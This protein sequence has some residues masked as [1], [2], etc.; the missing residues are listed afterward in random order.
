MS[1]HPRL[2]QK[3]N[4]IKTVVLCTLTVLFTTNLTLAQTG[5]RVP[6]KY[7]TLSIDTS[8]CFQLTNRY[9]LPVGENVVLSNNQLRLCL[10]VD[11]VNVGTMPIRVVL[12]IDF[13]G[14]MCSNTGNDPTN[15]RLLAAHSFI[16]SLARRNPNSEAG[17]VTF[18]AD[19][20]GVTDVVRPLRL[21]TQANIDSLH[22]V[23]Y[24]ARCPNTTD[25]FYPRG[26]PKTTKRLDTYQG[27]AIDSALQVVDINY[28]AADSIARH[29]LLLTDDGWR[30]TTDH[31]PTDVINKY[32]A[33][34][35]GR[36]IPVIHSVFLSRTSA[37]NDS[38]LQAIANL[39]HGM[40]IPNA[41][42]TTI[43]A[44]FMEILRSISTIRRQSLTQVSISNITT[45]QTHDATLRLVAGSQS[46]YIVSAPP[47]T[48][49]PGNNTY[50][51]SKKYTT[52]TGLAV[53]TSDTLFIQRAAGDPAMPA[54]SPFSK[55]CIVDTFTITVQCTPTRVVT[56]APITM[57]AQVD[58]AKAALFVAGSVTA[59]AL[60]T[61]DPKT[62]G[63]V[64][65]FHLDGYLTDAT[66]TYVA[67]G[68]P[69][70]SAGNAAFKSALSSGSFSFNGASLVSDCALDLWVNRT[71]A[72]AAGTL[73]NSALFSL[74]MLA[75]GRVRFTD[76]A[77]TITSAAPFSIGIWNHVALA[78]SGT[79]LVLFVNG[80]AV[81]PSA[82]SGVDLGGSI[83][84][85]APAGCVVDEVRISS[86]SRITSVGTVRTFQIP[87][88][89]VAWN[90][91]GV[92]SSGNTAL[93]PSALW[94]TPTLGKATLTFS[95]PLSCGIILSLE[96]NDGENDW[97]I[98]SNPVTISPSAIPGAPITI[99]LFD[100]NGNGYL[101]QM[102]LY[103]PDTVVLINPLPTAASLMGS[104]TLVT[105]HN[106]SATLHAASLESITAHSLRIRL[107][108][109]SG[110]IL[111]TGW[112]SAS[113]QFQSIIMTSNDEPFAAD[114]VLDSA[115]PVI[116]AAKFYP[117]AAIG[118]VDTLE[119]TL[120]EPISYSAPTIPSQLFNY[121]RQVAL[122]PAAFTGLQATDFLP[123]GSERLTLRIILQNGF[124]V[125]P[126]DS[127]QLTP[128][129]RDNAANAAPVN[130]R[131]APIQWAVPGNIK[132]TAGPNPFRIGTLI[133][134]QIRQFYANIIAPT[135]PA[136][137]PI[138][139]TIIGI[140][141]DK[142]LKIEADGSVGS[143][144]ILDALGNTV[145]KGL[146]VRQAQTYRDYGV[147]WDGKNQNGR[148][149]GNGTYLLIFKVTDIDNQSFSNR[150][151]I[152]VRR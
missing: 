45:G 78:R 96:H 42:P 122:L 23:I 2:S 108:E 133:P 60:T 93:L 137:Q 142:P 145:A 121:F 117:A 146:P 70:Y 120:S 26:L 130:G 127:L 9:T 69:V 114:R 94:S 52:E 43:V 58:Q 90:I 16:D 147:Y 57:T 12:A 75:D 128:M 85:T 41:T 77:I 30:V 72:S 136:S 118:G 13:S 27:F 135:A 53:A 97:I 132:A 67:T 82:A 107:T 91:A 64:A 86:Q 84:V 95:S 83:T 1:T 50:V 25:P 28:N 101:D 68:T 11:T 22:H 140:T 100:E 63:T 65:L 37:S 3:T 62:A 34:H 103:V 36:P 39:T 87:R 124:A 38:N 24:K 46:A 55:S 7:C 48:L 4:I 123:V 110:S 89:T 79:T 99:A 71:T 113:I 139:G 131:K 54:N 20:T 126:S 115:G 102:I 40:F 17:I 10:D 92:Q 134:D 29:I 116:Q 80:K 19:S 8:Q 104:M 56:D 150:I 141:S 5:Q 15:Q 49:A 66:G 31:S 143:A 149:V 112:R 21:N 74:T 125:V 151:K 81:S 88:T 144:F 59:T 109:N 32:R 148:S 119:A 111:E 76:G 138:T 51:I 129:A 44:R 61:A 6:S 35:P 18:V 105:Y 106:L 73:V 47:I 98:N 33:N 14:S 152:G